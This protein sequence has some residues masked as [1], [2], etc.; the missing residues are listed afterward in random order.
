[1]VT[2]CLLL[3]ERNAYIYIIEKIKKFFEKKLSKFLSEC[4]LDS[5]GILR[6]KMFKSV[7]FN[8]SKE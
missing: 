7:K 5:H 4:L 1:M 2:Y 8:T 6:L 3:C